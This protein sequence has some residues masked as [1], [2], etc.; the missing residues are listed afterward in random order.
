MAGV[1]GDLDNF[2]IADFWTKDIL[3]PES[4]Y[5]YTVVLKSGK[6]AKAEKLSGRFHTPKE[7]MEPFNFSF[8]FGSCAKTGSNSPVFQSILEGK[9]LFFLHTGDL[10]YGDVVVDSEKV[11]H[12]LY[13]RVLAR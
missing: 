12:D 8:A 5:T 10:H 4:A 11:Y 1:T 6:D 7:E 9:P 3:M 13:D 2:N